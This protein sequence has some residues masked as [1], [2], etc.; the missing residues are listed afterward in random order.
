MHAT[1]WRGCI[2]SSSTGRCAARQ[3]GY[4]GPLNRCSKVFGSKAAGD[5]LEAMLELEAQS[6]T[7]AG[8][9]EGDDEG[10]DRIDRFRDGA[11]IFQPLLT[12]LKEQNKGEKTGWMVAA[13]PMKAH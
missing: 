9:D 5:K 12:W 13:D 6:G 7:M 8:S 3:R 2:S 1:S 11:G 10:E 4:K